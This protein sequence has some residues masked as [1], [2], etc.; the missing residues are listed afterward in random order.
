ML[1]FAL[2]LCHRPLLYFFSASKL[3]QPASPL[4]LTWLLRMT[5]LIVIGIAYTGEWL[6]RLIRDRLLA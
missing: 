3:A 4:Q 1:T 6:R 5:F 2:Y